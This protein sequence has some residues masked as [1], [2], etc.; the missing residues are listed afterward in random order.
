MVSVV[1][2]INLFVKLDLSKLLYYLQTMISEV[3]EQY[4]W[5]LVRQTNLFATIQ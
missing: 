5:P 1:L 3:T 4:W 2:Q